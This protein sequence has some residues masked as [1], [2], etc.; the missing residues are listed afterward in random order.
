MLK[1]C[2]KEVK[3]VISVAMATYNSEKYIIKQLESIVNQTIKVDEVIIQD[4][5]ST[6]NTIKMIHEFITKN[7]LKNWS[8]DRN[9]ENMGYI[10][11]FK[12]AI[13]R[14]N[15][16]IIILCD[17]DDI[18]LND[19]SETIYRTFK[20]K[21]NILALATS[22]IEI[23]ENDNIIKTKTKLFHANNNL[24]RHNIKKGK[25]N[26]MKF[27]DVVS[28]NISPGCTCAFSN[29]IKNQLLKKD[30]QLPHDLQIMIIACL[31]NGL[32]YLDKVT[33]KY[34]IYSNNTIGLGHQTEL[35][36]RIKIV[37]AGLLEK[38]DLLTLCKRFLAT[39]KELNMIKRVIN[40]YKLRVSL[41][42]SKKIIKYFLGT[43]ICSLGLNKLYESVIMDL[44]T[45][46]KKREK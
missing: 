19:K 17:H 35:F 36:K 42:S 16:D 46:L 39:E 45:I 21:R 43:F 34:R 31:N 14:C 5:F 8:V 10:L 44:V 2:K 41:L 18:W 32:Y 9:K 40:T 28:F 24:I 3:N 1:K 6:D 26:K 11:T 25:L 23:D 4:D 33:T 13:K 37:K 12:K 22:F 29:K 15:G 7:G 27:K 38:E 20:D 30:Y